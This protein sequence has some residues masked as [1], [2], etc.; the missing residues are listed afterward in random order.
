MTP[1]TDEITRWVPRGERLWKADPADGS[2]T[3]R[4]Y[5]YYGVV[6]LFTF[7]GGCPGNSQI[8]HKAFTSMSLWIYPHEYS[9]RIHRHY[10]DRWLRRIANDFAHECYLLSEGK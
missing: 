2:T 3:A 5:T 6:E 10:H 9:K 4:I 7:P 1:A 8:F